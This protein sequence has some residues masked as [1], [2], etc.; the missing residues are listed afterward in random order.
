MGSLEAGD[1]AD[2]ILVD[3]TP[4]HMRP[5]ND[6]IGTLLYCAN[7]REVETVMVEGKL[8]MQEGKVNL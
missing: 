8:V 3:L 7:G 5:L 4:A 6:V 2:L 1:K